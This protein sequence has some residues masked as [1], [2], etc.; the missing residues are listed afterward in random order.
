MAK[1]PNF[2]FVLTDQQT[3]HHVSHAGNEL[4]QTPHI[5]RLAQYGS[6][7]EKFYVNSPICQPNRATIL[8]GRMPT[9]HGVRHN[10]I[11]LDLDAVTFVDVMRAGGYKTAL[12]GKSHFQNFLG[13]EPAFEPE[14]F[15]EDYQCVPTALN[16][17]RR[18]HYSKEHYQAE[19]SGLWR[20]DPDRNITLPYYGFDHVHLCAGHGDEVSGHYEKW[21]HDHFPQYVNKR[22]QVHGL[23]HSQFNSPQTY[24]PALPEEAYPTRYIEKQTIQYLE[25]YARSNE[26]EPFFLWCGF[27]D[28][29]HPF[30]PPG[31]YWDMY[32][33]EDISLPRSFYETTHDQLPPLQHLH[34]LHKDGPQLT[35]NTSPFIANEQQ[36]KEIIAKTY[37]QISMIDD[38]IGNII[39]QLKSLGLADNTIIIFTSDHGD[40]MG[41]HG[42]FLKGPLH[43]QNLIRVPF[44]WHDPSVEHNLSRTSELGSS[45]DIART[46]LC[47]A[48]LQPFNGMQGRDLLCNTQ[49]TDEESVLV[50]Q[51]TQFYYL[52]FDR[53]VHIYSLLVADWRLTIW[54]GCDWGELYHLNS[55]PEEL[56]NLWNSGEHLQIKSELMLKL[57]HKMQ[58]SQ[59]Q[60]PFPTDKA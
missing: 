41:S 53:L 47:R 27:P 23:E 12:I 58:D 56:H 42:L 48:K 25:D 9:L 7:L 8:T 36:A 43:Y 50:T 1:R 17:A 59:D 4:L 30:T 11:S 26:E 44:V 31:K 28:P 46:I 57:I 18:Q 51:T 37:G 19:L 13:S 60:S 20:R 22:G 21:L 39:T 54:Q 38:S 55:D 35:R 33:T 45:L 14:R 24:K 16:E 52:G 6:R 15:P 49:T 34:G 3:F 5:D 10:G 29:H 2:L 40:W 32:Q